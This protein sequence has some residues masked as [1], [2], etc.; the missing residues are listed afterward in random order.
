MKWGPEVTYQIFNIP[1]V[2]QVCT[3]GQLNVQ[4]ALSE[5]NIQRGDVFR[6]YGFTIEKLN[7]GY[8]GVF[9]YFV[10]EL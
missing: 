8:D 1:Q 10:H 2:L 7:Y 6:D 5:D 4:V 9:S 3:Y